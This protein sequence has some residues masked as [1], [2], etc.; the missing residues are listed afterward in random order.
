MNLTEDTIH[1]FFSPQ[2]NTSISCWRAWHFYCAE[3]HDISK[4][5]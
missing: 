1:C 3:Y 5:L 2:I 4:E